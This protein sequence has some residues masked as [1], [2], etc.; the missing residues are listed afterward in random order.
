MRG[1]ASDGGDA[2]LYV[3]RVEGKRLVVSG[4]GTLHADEP[5]LFVPSGSDGADTSYTVVWIQQRN[6]SSSRS[7]VRTYFISHVLCRC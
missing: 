5:T 7:I 4:E 3:T 6:D 2:V 1:L